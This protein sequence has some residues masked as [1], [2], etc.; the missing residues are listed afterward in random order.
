MILTTITTTTVTN[1]RPQVA[2]Q[3]SE[4]V[5]LLRLIPVRERI[6]M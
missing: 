6:L 2:G 3:V 4:Q 5:E 1:I